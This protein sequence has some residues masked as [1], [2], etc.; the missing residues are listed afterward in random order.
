MITTSIVKSRILLIIL[1]LSITL[2]NGFVFAPTQVL[3]HL[4]LERH[5]SLSDNQQGGRQDNIISDPLFDEKLNIIYDSK[6]SVCQFEVN[7]LQD[8]MDKHFGNSNKP[9]IRFTDLESEEGYDEGDPAN[10][11]VTYEMGMKS[12]HA[13]KSNGE[14]L[15]GVPVFREAYEIVDREW[16]WEVTKYPIIGSLV[17]QGY[18]IFARIR[19]QLT[20][21]SSVEDLIEIHQQRSEQEC[22]PCQRRANTD[23]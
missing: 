5:E 16:V 11:G 20:R 21:G 3:N 1:A 18:D 19:T 23:E 13:V 15:H 14:V 4:Q 22:E 9:L 2:A 7:Y 10:G 8:R 17:S 12:F 6:C